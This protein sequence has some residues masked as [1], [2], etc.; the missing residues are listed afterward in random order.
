[1]GFGPFALA[2]I[3]VGAFAAVGALG[4]WI[5]SKAGP[6][7]AAV[8]EPPRTP[9]PPAS[10]AEREVAE[11]P[12]PRPNATAPAAAIAAQVKPAAHA[13]RA[14]TAVPADQRASAAPDPLPPAPAPAR[15]QV[16]AERPRP[17]SAG[18]RERFM[19]RESTRNG[20]PNYLL[21]T[22]PW[23]ALDRVSIEEPAHEEKVVSA[24]R[25]LDTALTWSR[26]PAEAAEQAA[27]EDKLVF[28]IHVS[29]NFEN[30]G[31]T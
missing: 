3:V 29:G 24:D 19:L 7:E 2:I 12:H 18:A 11:A 6:R 5:E 25:T 9:P 30:P 27:R 21:P 31:F 10:T 15:A 14:Q 16:A 28:L 8:A 23:F 20:S 4:M 1:V 22:D 17:N 26:S 13:D